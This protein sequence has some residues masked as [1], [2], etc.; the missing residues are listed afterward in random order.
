MTHEI[1]TEESRA[2]DG[3]GWLLAFSVAD[4][5][6]VL[7]GHFPGEP[8]VPG[9]AL[10]ELARRCA[11]DLG[12]LERAAGVERVRLRNPV[13]PGDRIELGLRP[14]GDGVAFDLR[15][16]DERVA[17]GRFTAGVRP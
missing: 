14:D 13:R 7:R 4:G 10:V 3:D 16:G 9:F 1:L 2:A 8:I 11:L 5:A 12:L 17:G 6:P 15:R